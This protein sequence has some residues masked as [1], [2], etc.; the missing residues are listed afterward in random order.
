MIQIIIFSFN[1]ALQ[2]DALLTSIKKFWNN[3]GYKLTVLYNTTNSDFQKGYEL[4]QSK[5][6][7]CHFIKETN[8][9]T[10]YPISNYFSWFNL[11]KIIKYK[12][13]RYTKSN[14]RDLLIKIISESSCE[15]V[16]FLTDDSIFI[17]E[18]EIKKEILNWINQNPNQH[19]FSLRLGTSINIPPIG[20][21]TPE[22]NIISW[23]YP[24]YIKYKNWG[25]RFSV[26]GHIYSKKIIL[27]LIT[28]I[29][30]NN[31][32]TLEAHLYDYSVRHRLLNKGKTCTKPFLLSFP[33][34]MVQTI[35]NNE[36]LGI[37]TKMLNDYF[38][39]GYV[40]TYPI[41]SSIVTFQQYPDSL[42]LKSHTNDFI[43]NTKK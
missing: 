32:S 24:Q 10:G 16:M 2:L 12:H 33:I 15:Q 28:R 37:S 6:S 38:L 29:I 8:Y 42:Y 21:P 25:Y 40:L 7:D 27:R 31:P 4:L 22:D 1:R 43:L 20:L 36:S 34:N 17:R 35:E 19:S 30:F 13:C 11:K 41:P 23:T 5:Y 14:F 9:K 39:K 26:D 18:V 3:T